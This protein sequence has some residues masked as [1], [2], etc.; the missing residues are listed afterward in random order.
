MKGNNI[1]QIV[2]FFVYLLIQ[3]LVFK[4]VALFGSG[5]I[6][7][8]VAFLLLLPVDT[9][10]STLLV[11]GFLSGLAVDWFYDSMGIHAAAMVALAYLRPKWMGMIMPKGGY[12]AG[13]LPLVSNYGFNWFAAYALPL[14][15]VHHFLLFVIQAGG[16]AM[17]VNLLVKSSFSMLLTFIL[18][19]L[20]QSLFYR[21][22][23]KS[24]E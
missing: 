20:S 8:Y 12:D 3:V 6:M 9:D 17:P 21:V 5:F 13:T 22:K 14:I 24:Y 4:G 10:K 16:F 15:F 11:L 1:L 19:V 18:I 7:I 23:R 2:H